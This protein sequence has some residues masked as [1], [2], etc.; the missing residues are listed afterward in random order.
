VA[1]GNDVQE[2]FGLRNDKEILDVINSGE[3]TGSIARR[4]RVA[5]RSTAV[6]YRSAVKRVP[7]GSAIIDQV[8]AF[9]ETNLFAKAR[10][11]DLRMAITMNSEF[12]TYYND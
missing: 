12:K 9:V 11:S 1:S 2:L 3:S 8:P 10:I 5:T 4:L 6:K 7:G